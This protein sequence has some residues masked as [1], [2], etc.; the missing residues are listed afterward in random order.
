M[1]HQI[2]FKF[3]FTFYTEKD[4]THYIAFQEN[5]NILSKEL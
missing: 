5:W 3:S 4:C 2:F 1:S